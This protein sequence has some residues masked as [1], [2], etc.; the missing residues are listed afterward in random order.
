LN[1]VSP[2]ALPNVSVAIARY[3]PLRRT[4]AAPTRTL[5][6]TVASAANGTASQNGQ[7]QIATATPVVKAPMPTN[8]NGM[9]EINPA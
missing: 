6:G 9:R 4:D 7:P 5:M 8:V 3:R 1:I 2:I